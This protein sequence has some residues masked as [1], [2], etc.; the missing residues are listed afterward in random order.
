[1]LS[2]SSAGL[3][4]ERLGRDEGDLDLRRERRGGR[5]RG[6]E[7]AGGLKDVVLL[8]KALPPLPPPPCPPLSLPLCLSLSL[9]EGEEE[10]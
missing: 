3:G 8:L 4:L 2:K 1:M 6:G 9:P 5:G 10:A 7:G